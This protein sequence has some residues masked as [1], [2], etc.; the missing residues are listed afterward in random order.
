VLKLK[1]GICHHASLGFHGLGLICIGSRYI[2]HMEVKFFKSV[3]G[4]RRWFV[5]NGH[6]ATEIWIGFYNAKSARKGVTYKEAVDEALCFGWIDGIRK[7]KDE[8]S[9]TNRFT[10][11]KKKSNWSNVNTKRMQELI[12]QG[13]VEEA[14]MK[15]WQARDDARTGIYS[16]ENQPASLL[17]AFEKEFRANKKAWSYFTSTAPWYQRTAI[18]LVMSAKQEETKLK[19]L[20]MLIKDSA[21]GRT[22]AQLTRNPRK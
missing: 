12:A 3:A 4:L 6:K 8:E 9:Y 21:A 13:R 7:S 22:I 14:G 5:N 15:A 11:R 10:P 20:R 17:P 18:H 19:R 2:L 16:F 1:L